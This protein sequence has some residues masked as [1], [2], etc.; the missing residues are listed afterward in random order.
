[1]SIS[2]FSLT[3]YA[4]KAVWSASIA[5]GLALHALMARQRGLVALLLL[6]GR[7]IAI[8]RLRVLRV[9]AVLLIVARLMMARA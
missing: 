8:D 9:V 5:L 1:M 4:S 7:L 3:F 6:L 2:A